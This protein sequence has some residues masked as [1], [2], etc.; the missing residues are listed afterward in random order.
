MA[1]AMNIKKFE[2]LGAS[3]K[4]WKCTI[5]GSGCYAV[6]K[7]GR[8]EEVVD[9]NK[10]AFGYGEQDVRADARLIAAAPDLYEAVRLLLDDICRKCL[11]RN[12]GFVT[13]VGECMSTNAAKIALKKAE[14]KWNV[15]EEMN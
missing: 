15:K 10:S 7:D 13:C 6:I 4:P 2:E 1:T 11:R 14:G 12:Y 9:L 8:G 5:K 3:P